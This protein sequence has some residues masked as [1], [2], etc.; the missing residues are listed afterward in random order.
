MV[1]TT[2]MHDRHLA[3]LVEALET[4]HRWVKSESVGDLDDL[5]LRNA[6]MGP[7]AVIRRVFYDFVTRSPHNVRDLR[8]DSLP[9]AH[10]RHDGAFDRAG[11]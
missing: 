1:V 4:D 6:Q 9:L 7:R 8:I 3:V 10:F 2:A 11:A 5:A